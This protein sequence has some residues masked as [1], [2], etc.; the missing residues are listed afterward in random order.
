MPIYH[1]TLNIIVYYIEIISYL[2]YK[3]QKKSSLYAH[4]IIYFNFKKQLKSLF[5][6]YPVSLTFVL[7]MYIEKIVYL[8]FWYFKSI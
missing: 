1:I 8:N 3:K 6:F 7:Q 5:F 2:R 4:G